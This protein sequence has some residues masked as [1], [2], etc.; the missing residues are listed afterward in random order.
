MK[1]ETYTN[2]RLYDNED[3]DLLFETENEAY[4]FIKNY[5]K[6]RYLGY[7]FKQDLTKDG[8]ICIDYG[9]HYHFFY[10]KNLK[11]TEENKN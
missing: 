9:S 11:Y 6:K 4:E 1:Y 5:A 3:I 8:E 2:Y 7:Y 10:L